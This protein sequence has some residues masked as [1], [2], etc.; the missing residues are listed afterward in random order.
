MQSALRAQLLLMTEYAEISAV[1]GS[2]LLATDYIQLDFSAE[3]LLESSS[4]LTCG[5]VV[6][7][8]ET[9]LTCTAT[10]TSGYLSSV[11]VEG[12]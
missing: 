8:T 4:A 2:T 11:K 7:G 3:F 1:L 10:Y 9:A 6:S 5:K 12:L